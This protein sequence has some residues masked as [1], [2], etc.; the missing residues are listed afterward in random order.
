M[1]RTELNGEMQKHFLGTA[2]D[3]V[4]VVDVDAHFEPGDDWL[5]PYPDLAKRLPPLNPGLL[6]AH[7]IVGD[8]LHDVPPE[9]RPPISQLVPPSLDVLYGQE[10]AGEK[11]RRAEFEG[12]HQFQVANAQSRLKWMDEQGIHLQHVICLAGIAYGLQVEDLGLRQEAI[13]TANTWLADTCAAGKGRLL[14]VCALEYGSL[15]W[16]IAELSRMRMLGSRIFLIPAYPVNG[17]PP[18]H[19]SWDALWEAAVGLGMVPML[20]TGFER[21]RFDPGWANLGGDV[22][23]MRMLGSGQ[24]QVAPNTLLNGMVYSGVFERFPQLTVLL[25]EVGT[26]WLPFLYREIDDRTAPVAEL[27]LGSWK[28]PLKPSEYLARNVRATPLSGGNDRPL[29]R[30]IED[31]PPEMLVFSSDFPHF[32]GFTNPAQYFAEAMAD[33]SAETRAAFAGGTIAEVFGRMGQP[34]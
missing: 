4:A 11:A 19:P 20:H 3:A 8:L 18:I 23:L 7:A 34:L 2:A 17:V 22:T 14:P 10:K 9:D 5:L 33:C 21:M 13:R 6:A 16:A 32:E 28:L 26:G 29:A 15:D 1:Q 30:I 25:A 24:R 12:K 31:L 27:F